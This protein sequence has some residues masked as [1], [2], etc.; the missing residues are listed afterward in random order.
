[1]NNDTAK[2]LDVRFDSDAGDNLSVREYLKALLVKLWK[3]GEGFSGKRPFGNS[4]W[5]L[6]LYA[7]LIRAGAISGLID[8]DGCVDEFDEKQASEFVLALIDA[9]FDVSEAAK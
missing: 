7:P 3:D 1:M 5:E 8:D 2:Y 9:V 6:D 4:G